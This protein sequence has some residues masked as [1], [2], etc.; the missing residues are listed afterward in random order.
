LANYSHFTG[1]Q[2][3][4]SKFLELIQRG[5]RETG[6]DYIKVIKE[7]IGDYGATLG[8]EWLQGLVDD[9]NSETA[10]YIPSLTLNI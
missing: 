9:I 1:N 5:I 8:T 7:G 10:K 3:K 4:R 6:K 2:E